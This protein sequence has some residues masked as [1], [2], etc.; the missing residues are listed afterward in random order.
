MKHDLIRQLPDR[1]CLTKSK[2]QHK[3]LLYRYKPKVHNNKV[4]QYEARRRKEIILV[5]QGC[6]IKLPQIKSLKRIEICSLQVPEANHQKSRCQ[7]AMLT[8]KAQR[9]ECVPCLSPSFW[10]CLGLS[11]HH[12]NPYPCRPTVFSLV[13]L[14]P[15]LLIRPSLVL[16][17]A[18][19]NFILT[20]LYPQRPYFQIRLHSQVLGVQNSIHLLGGHNSIY[21]GMGQ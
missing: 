21:N 2:F 12:F 18:H 11:T 7:Q 20:C 3:P 8:L 16:G 19:L 9:G 6:Y 10:Y 1:I 14:S 4:P 5:S 17:K 13:C 15:P